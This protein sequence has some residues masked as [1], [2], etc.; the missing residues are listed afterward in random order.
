MRKT[1]CIA[2]AMLALT[3]ST[4]AVAKDGTANTLTARERSAG[5]KLLFDGRNL[6]G[7]GSFSG[8]AVAGMAGA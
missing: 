8:G 4:V 2:L 5:W 6:N 1:A 7:W 3:G